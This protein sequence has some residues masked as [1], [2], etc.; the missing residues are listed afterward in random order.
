VSTSGTSV[1]FC[2]STRHNIP[3]DSHVH[4]G[5]FFKIQFG[6]C[7]LLRGNCHDVNFISR[8]FSLIH[9]NLTTFSVNPVTNSVAPEPEGSSSHPREPADGPCRQPDESTPHTPPPSQ[10][11]VYVD[12]ILPSTP[13]S[14]RRSFSFGL[15]L[16][17]FLPS[18]MRS[19]CPAHFIHLD[20]IC[21]I[22]CG[23]ENKLWSFPLCNFLGVNSLTRFSWNPL[24]SF[25]DKATEF[26]WARFVEVPVWN[27]LLDVAAVISRDW[28][29]FKYLILL[30]LVGQSRSGALILSETCCYIH[31]LLSPRGPHC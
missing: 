26:R 31:R 29:G 7:V 27:V 8:L 14:F 10:S 12:P 1:N 3:E 5:I 13:W 20:L 11:K 19:T 9:S 22:M 21:L 30:F 2:H 4:F 17:K 23:D 6:F 25:R 18:A 28:P 15:S 16:H 24:G